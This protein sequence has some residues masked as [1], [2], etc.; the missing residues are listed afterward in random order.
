VHKTRTRNTILTAVGF[1]AWL[2]YVLAC[3]PAFSPDDTK[4]LF[5][6]LDPKTAATTLAM[7]DRTTNTTRTLLVPRDRRQASQRGEGHDG[8]SLGSAWTPDG[9]RAIGF[10]AESTEELR[11]AIIPIKGA[12]P[13]RLLTIPNLDDVPQ[14]VV[15]KLAI[16]GGSLFVTTKE[17]VVRVDLAT[18]DTTSK[19]LAGQP[20]LQS[21]G[22]R[23]YYLKDL[24]DKPERELR[25]WEFGRLDPDTLTPTAAFQSEERVARFWEVSADGSRL[26]VQQEVDTVWHIVVLA[27]TRVER[28]IPVG[29]RESQVLPFNMTWSR[30]GSTIYTT[31]QKVGDKGLSEFGIL[32]LPVN[33]SA[34]RRTPLFSMTLADDENLG[35][36]QLDLS[37]DRRTVA[38]SS[39]F[40]A[41]SGNKND[42]KPEDCALYLVD[43]S[44]A[45]RRVTKIA[46]PMP[47][48][49]RTEPAGK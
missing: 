5:P 47:Q 45:D 28:R 41:L 7:Y 13:V 19:P 15:Q 1:A 34:P 12:E 16:L 31:Y 10:W 6:S 26:A 18:G 36:F 9:Q 32:E 40:L 22:G 29:T 38:A 24:M 8:M 30:D 35:G 43:L 39:T 27:G 42:M 49:A 23:L 37:H 25:K 4:V 44:R 20:L 2:A 17:D 11:V 3:A 48:A 21:R 14:L 33:G 46:I